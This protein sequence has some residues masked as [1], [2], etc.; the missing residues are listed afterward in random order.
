MDSPDGAHVERRADEREPA[1]ANDPAIPKSE[2]GDLPDLQSLAISESKLEPRPLVLTT[3]ADFAPLGQEAQQ[4]MFRR[5]EAI[6]QTAEEFEGGVGVAELRNVPA[7]EYE[8]DE[9]SPAIEARNVEALKE[10]RSILDQM[11]W[12]ESGFLVN[13]AEVMADASRESELP[14]HELSEI[15]SVLSR[16]ANQLKG[17]GASRSEILA[18]WSFSSAFVPRKKQSQSSNYTPFD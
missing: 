10:V 4:R 6:F 1:T 5:L 8:Q 11:W 18:F 14:L 2:Q 15:E 3:P 12:S 17:I 16:N 7:E 13:V 9:P